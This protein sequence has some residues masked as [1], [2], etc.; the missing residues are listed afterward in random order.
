MKNGAGMVRVCGVALAVGAIV[1][2]A[3]RTSGSVQVAS[4]LERAGLATSSERSPRPRRPRRSTR[5]R[6]P[7]STSRPMR[8]AV[9]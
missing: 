3:T 8:R 1:F 2:G 5:S 9:R 4:T 7:V 6:M